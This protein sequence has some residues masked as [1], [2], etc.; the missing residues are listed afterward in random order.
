MTLP[1]NPADRDAYRARQSAAAI[2][3]HSHRSK[4]QNGEQNTNFK[5]GWF[6]D[7]NGY[8]VQTRMGKYL[9]EHRV[10]MEQMIGRPLLPQE[11]VHHK[12]GKRD[13]NRPENLELWS[14]RNPK[15]Q[16]IIDKLTWAREMFALY[17]TPADKPPVDSS[18]VNGL[19]FC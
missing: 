14:S 17:G 16:R 2:A 11:T 4:H 15:G 8:C 18:F 7:K 5:R 3:S 10:V 19:L 13:D 9:F 6:L 12:N 1:N